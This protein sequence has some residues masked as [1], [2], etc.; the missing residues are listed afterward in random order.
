MFPLDRSFKSLG[1]RHI[2]RDPSGLSP[3]TNELTQSVGFLILFIK[4]FLSI[5]FNSFLRL[6]CKATG[7]SWRM[8]NRCCILFYVDVMFS[9]FSKSIE[10][11][12]KRVFNFL[13]QSFV[14]SPLIDLV[15]VFN[16]FESAS[17]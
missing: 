14:A 2:R 11:F 5:V 17:S 3:S 10:D 1:W 7:I 16:F 13:L 6:S 15:L 4:P 9:K 8:N 12:R